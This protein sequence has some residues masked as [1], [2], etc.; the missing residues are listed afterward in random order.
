MLG[1]MTTALE[2]VRSKKSTEEER[3]PGKC[4]RARSSVTYREFLNLAYRD[5]IDSY[6]LF[7][8]N[9]RG[10]GKPSVKMWQPRFRH[11]DDPESS[12]DQ[13][14]TCRTSV[15]QCFACS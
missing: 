8:D 9:F 2:R 1:I 4:R 5:E 15:Y 11:M 13:D 12:D 3:E 10:S 6:V 7:G 14:R